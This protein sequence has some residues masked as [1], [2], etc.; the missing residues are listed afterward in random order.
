MKS[1]LIAIAIAIAAGVGSVYATTAEITLF[2]GTT[3]TVIM[4]NGSGD[5]NP[6]VGVIQFTGS[7]GVWNLTITNGFTKPFIGGATHPQMDLGFQVNSVGAGTLRITFSDFGFT[8][9]G[10]ATDLFGGT[11]AGTV[12]DF[13]DIN[14]SHVAGLHLGPFGPGAFSGTT[15][16]AI[17]LAPADVLGLEVDITHTGAGFSSGDKELTTPDSGSAVALFGIALAGIEILRRKIR[18]AK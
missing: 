11:T 17:T 16:G 6:A 8:F 14:G 18:A 1:I 13:I 9:G 12:D 4:D 3:T 2:D 15:S 10:V 7:I 5:S